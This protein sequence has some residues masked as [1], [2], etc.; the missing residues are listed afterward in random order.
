MCPAGAQGCRPHWCA[1]R[2]RWHANRVRAATQRPTPF[3]AG[4]WPSWGFVLTRYADQYD[5]PDLR[6]TLDAL[7]AWNPGVLAREELAVIR[8]EIRV[9]LAAA[10]TA[11]RQLTLGDKAQLAQ[12]LKHLR[13]MRSLWSALLPPGTTEPHGEN[14]IPEFARKLGEVWSVREWTFA[15]GRRAIANRNQYVTVARQIPQFADRPANR[16]ATYYTKDLAGVIAIRGK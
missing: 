6:W 4:K 9:V 11:R 7:E 3:L 5:K 15:R 2:P 14:F 8:G 16:I 1:S 13:T 12:A 10:T